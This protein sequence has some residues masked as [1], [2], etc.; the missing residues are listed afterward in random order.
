MT[1]RD[2]TKL[3]AKREFG[4][5]L[6]LHEQLLAQLQ[7]VADELSSA[8]TKALLKEIR[9]QTGSSPAL[10]EVSSATEEAIKALKLSESQVRKAILETH[11]S[12]EIDGIPNLP[13]HIQRFLAERASVPGFSYEV[14][15]DEVRG[16]II[17]WK[18]YTEKGTVRGYGQITER[19]YAWIED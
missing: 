11:D 9:A 4:Q 1:D 10:S 15:Q 16:W 18:E 19:P 5:L 2:E 3:Q 6:R 14:V 8:N 13:A 12:M 17:C 7:R